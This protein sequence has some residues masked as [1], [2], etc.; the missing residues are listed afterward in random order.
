MAICVLDIQGHRQLHIKERI[1]YP[2]QHDQT[3]QGV[4]LRHFPESAKVRDEYLG[5]V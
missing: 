3:S 5:Y 2:V 1:L 4:D